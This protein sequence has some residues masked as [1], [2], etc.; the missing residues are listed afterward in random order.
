ME[1]KKM[2]FVLFDPRRL[3]RV[4]ISRAIESNI[5][6]SVQKYRIEHP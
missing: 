2:E 3:G 5:F 1:E 6:K 4:E